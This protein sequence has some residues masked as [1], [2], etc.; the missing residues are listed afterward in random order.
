MAGT[1]RELLRPELA[2]AGVPETFVS[3]QLLARLPENLAPAPWDARCQATIWM[4]RGGK[5]ARAALRTGLH[6]LREDLQGH[7]AT[8]AF[9]LGAIDSRH[10]SVPDARPDHIGAKSSALGENPRRARRRDGRAG[11]V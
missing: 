7:L 9:V 10:A 8:Q 6:A 4:S 2:V 3:E 11:L 1:D 5:E